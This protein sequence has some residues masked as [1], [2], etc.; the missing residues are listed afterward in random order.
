MA[1]FLPI[2]FAARKQSRMSPRH[3]S[4]AVM[5]EVL[6]TM[7]EDAYLRRDWA[8]FEQ[9]FKAYRYLRHASYGEVS[10]G[11][12]A[13]IV[14]FQPLPAGLGIPPPFGPMASSDGEA[15]DRPC[16]HPPAV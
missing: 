15:R 4:R 12:G 3:R 13:I 5:R 8:N 1:E 10:P 7:C 2:D 14:P 9:Y 11:P 6:L 16:L